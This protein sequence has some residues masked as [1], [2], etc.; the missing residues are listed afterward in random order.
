MEH[1]QS[2]KSFMKSSYNSIKHS[3]YFDSYDHFFKDFR[4]KKITF[5]E[6]GVL[7]G[8]SLFMWRDYFGPKARII[9]I[10]FNPNAKKWE[11]HGFEI[12]IGSQSD[13][14][15]WN[16]FKTKVGNIDILLD[17][18]GHTY[19][20]QI[21]T[22]EC[23]LD[24]INDGG[25]LVIEDTHS[26]YMKN[27]GKRKYSFIEYTKKK[28]DSINMRFKDISGLEPERRIWSIE[29]VES[30]VAFKINKKASYMKSEPI[31]N[32]GENDHAEDYVYRNADISAKMKSFF[33]KVNISTDNRLVKRIIRKFE[34]ISTKRKF[35]AKKYFD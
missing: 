25:L 26:S 24:A 28:V 35:S 9:G 34:K 19:E 32:D 21:I 22:T 29:F 12:F 4:N 31:S 23:L 13:E 17:D 27:Y 8:G 20:Q 5:V 11:K 30:M 15:F 6:I 14:N 3:T 18:G 2:Y 10:D 7:A 33:N 1:S 16:E